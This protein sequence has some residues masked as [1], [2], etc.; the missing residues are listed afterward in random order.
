MIALGD[1][2]MVIGGDITKKI[3]V[4]GVHFEEIRYLSPNYKTEILLQKTLK[5]FYISYTL[6][7][8]VNCKTIN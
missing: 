2:I 7:K 3:E 5:L 4:K 1:R 8:L 6:L